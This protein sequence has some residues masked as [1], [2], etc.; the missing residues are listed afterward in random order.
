VQFKESSAGRLHHRCYQ[1]LAARLR[2]SKKATTEVRNPTLQQPTSQNVL[3]YISTVILTICLAS[4]SVEVLRKSHLHGV[5][6][7][8][9]EEG[10]DRSARP[11]AAA[12]ALEHVLQHH[13]QLLDLGQVPPDLGKHDVHHLEQLRQVHLLG[14]RSVLVRQER[15]PLRH[16]PATT[17][18]SLLGKPK[19]VTK[20]VA[21]A[22]TDCLCL[23]H[24]NAGPQ[25]HAFCL[26]RTQL[27]ETGPS[28][29]CVS[30][31]VN[32][33]LLILIDNSAVRLLIKRLQVQIGVSVKGPPNSKGQS[34]VSFSIL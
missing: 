9:V 30:S 12:A 19:A 26:W 5:L 6:G 10:V 29:A 18:L 2:T 34:M 20:D 17:S 1:S 7:E 4:S 21:V 3:W 27:L 24:M 15:E 31:E 25:K 11:D 23:T 14:A 28:P 32:S 16:L 22:L 8:E 13:V 33:R